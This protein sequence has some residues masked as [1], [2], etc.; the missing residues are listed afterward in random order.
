[1]ALSIA[2]RIARRIRG[3]RRALGLTQDQ[4]ADALGVPPATIEA[5]E[6]AT[7]SVPPEHLVKLAELFEVSPSYFLL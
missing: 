2:R 5:Y 6:R 7:L 3:K 1:M 4:V